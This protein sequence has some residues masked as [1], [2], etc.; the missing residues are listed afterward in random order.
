MNSLIFFQRAPVWSKAISFRACNKVPQFRATN[1]LC[2]NQKRFFSGHDSHLQKPE[3]TERVIN[4]LKHFHKLQ[5]QNVG[6]D[7]RFSELG[8]DSLDTVEVVMAFEDE[9]AI[10][11]PDSEAEKIQSSPDAINYIMSHPQAK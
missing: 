7:S 5:D 6:P 1:N 10:E 3:V 2:W 4:V 11:I 9:F 8:L